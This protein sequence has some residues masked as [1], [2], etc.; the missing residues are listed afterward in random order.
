M[1]P[2]TEPGGDV[3]L[4]D[5]I[6]RTVSHFTH[7]DSGDGPVHLATGYVFGSLSLSRHLALFW[8]TLS[9]DLS[10]VSLAP[11]SL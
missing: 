7:L 3:P 8:R 6:G 4:W 5:L 1:S 11:P 9:R 2:N 10:V